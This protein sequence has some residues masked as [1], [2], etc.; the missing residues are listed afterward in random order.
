[1]RHRS[2]AR[3]EMQIINLLGQGPAQRYRLSRLWKTTALHVMLAS[4]GSLQ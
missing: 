1:M 4:A 2:D 3:A